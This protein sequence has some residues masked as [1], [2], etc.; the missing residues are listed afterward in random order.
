MAAFGDLLEG[1]LESLGR[2]DAGVIAAHVYGGFMGHLT[3]FCEEYKIP[4]DG[5]PVGTIKKFWTGKGNASK[6]EMLE[7]AV[8]RGWSPVDD[9]EADAIAILTLKTE[10]RSEGVSK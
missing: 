2:G 4:Y 8:R 10:G 6:D 7:E 3:A 1:F 5:V 9:N